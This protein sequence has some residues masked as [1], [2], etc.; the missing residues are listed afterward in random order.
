MSVILGGLM[1]VFIGFTL[2]GLVAREKINQEK[3]K[4]SN[5]KKVKYY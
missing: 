1:G 5:K 4:Y 3:H 2:L